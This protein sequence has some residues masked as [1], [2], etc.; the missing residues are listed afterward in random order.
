MA[1]TQDMRSTVFAQQPVHE[2]VYRRHILDDSLLQTSLEHAVGDFLAI[3]T[4]AAVVAGLKVDWQCK[5]ASRHIPVC[6]RRQPIE[7]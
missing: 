5:S 3:F 4:S 7:L 2:L 6:A 1:R